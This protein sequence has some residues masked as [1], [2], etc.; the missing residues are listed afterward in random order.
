MPA[1]MESERLLNQ[2]KLR[3]DSYIHLRDALRND[4]DPRNIGKMCIP[5]ATFTGSPLYIHARTQDAMTY[6]QKYGRPDLFISFTC[7]PKWYAIAKELM[8]GQSAY[9]RPDLNERVYHL[10]LGKLMDVITKGQVF[11]A[12][13]CRMHTIEWQKRDKIEATEIDHLISAEI[14]DPSADPELYE[15]VT[16]NMIHGPCGS[17]YNY[18]SCH[19]SDGKCTR[20]YPRDFVSETITGSNDYP[21]YRRRS[22]AEGGFTDVVKGHQVDNRWV[23]PYC[24]LLTKASNAHINVEYCHSVRSI[25]YVCKYINKG[26]NAAMFGIRQEGSVD[27]I[28]DFLSGRVISSTEDRVASSSLSPEI[29]R[30]TSYSV[31]LTRSTLRSLL[32]SKCTPVT[33]SVCPWALLIVIAKQGANG[34][35]DLLKVKGTS[36]SDG[37]KCI[38]GISTCSPLPHYCEALNSS[39]TNV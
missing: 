17:H 2:T 20:Q 39:P 7:N 38:L 16:T 14:P 37:Y 27:E 35:G 13:C 6:V 19:N 12:V 3:C 30:E 4:A 5:P 22:P 24:P 15:I 28:Q 26:T 36:A 1:K 31:L 18:T 21:L 8:P 10:K 23:V 33:D 25:K 32:S 11:G 29:V 34:N 9:H